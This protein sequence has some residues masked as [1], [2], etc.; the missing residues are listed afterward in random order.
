MRIWPQAA[1]QPDS[2]THGASA[3]A[4]RRPAELLNKL[5][6]KLKKY[7]IP[8]LILLFGLLL[9]V[10]PGRFQKKTSE[11]SIESPAVSNQTKADA[12][13]SA[14]QYR[15]Q[16]QRS[17]AAALSRISGAGRVEVLLT[18]KSGGTTQ[19]LND[20]ET[21]T[22]QSGDTQSTATRQSTVLIRRGSAYDEVT[23]VKTEYPLF[24]GALI[25]SEG[26]DHAAVRLA[27]CEAVSALLGLGTDRI[28]VVKMK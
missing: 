21:T 2:K 14:E 15:L 8:L 28:T 20:V 23:V 24:Q 7:K 16:M 11:D 17:L 22:Q 4:P 10:L 6:T 5:T 9:T 18:L 25:V 1:K 13:S 12:L 27:L 26:A 19:Y 3:Q